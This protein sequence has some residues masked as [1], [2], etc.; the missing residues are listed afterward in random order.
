MKKEIEEHKKD[1]KAESMEA[2]EV[3]AKKDGF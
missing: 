3:K 1:T 2:K